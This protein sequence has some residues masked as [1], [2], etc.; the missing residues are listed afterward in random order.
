MAIEKGQSGDGETFTR[1]AYIGDKALRGITYLWIR[2]LFNGG[3]PCYN[4]LDRYLLDTCGFQ[5]DTALNILQNFQEGFVHHDIE[6]WK[7]DSN[8]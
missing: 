8:H 1:D 7:L 5:K 2:V 6:R 4:E 3:T